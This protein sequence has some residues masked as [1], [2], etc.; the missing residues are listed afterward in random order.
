MD[1]GDILCHLRFSWIRI[2]TVLAAQGLK[3]GSA[4]SEPWLSVNPLSSSDYKHDKKIEIGILP[5]TC[6]FDIFTALATT[7]PEM[8]MVSLK[9]SW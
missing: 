5:A 6:S 8:Q 2:D 9:K 3:S 4:D 7:E 1:V